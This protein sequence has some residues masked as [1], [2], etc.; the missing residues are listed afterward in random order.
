MFKEIRREKKK[1]SEE[2]TLKVLS[3]GEYGVLATMS[4]N[5][6]PY[7]TPLSYVYI[8]DSIY[9]HSALEGHKLENIAANNKVSFCVTTDIEL[10]PEEFS[11]KYK[12]VIAFGQASEVVG[13][14]KNLALLAFIS[15]YSPNYAIEGT[16]YI[17]AASNKTIVIKIVIDHISGKGGD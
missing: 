4:T 5:G 17:Q 10:L 9:F 15:K 11:T 7:T 3:E 12:S 2:E 8:N 16:K 14:E 1:M 6:Y 13:E